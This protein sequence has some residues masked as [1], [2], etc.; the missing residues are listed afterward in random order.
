MSAKFSYYIKN[1]FLAEECQGVIIK[2]IQDSRLF[3]SGTV[4]IM[5]EIEAD[6]D[7]VTDSNMTDFDMELSDEYNEPDENDSGSNSTFESD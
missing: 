1:Y 6:S 3:I 5:E 7:D 4:E 2:Q